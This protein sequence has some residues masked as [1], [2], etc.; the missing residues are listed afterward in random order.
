[1]I[2]YRGTDA[3]MGKPHDGADTSG[4]RYF[5]PFLSLSL[6]FG[7]CV[8][9]GEAAQS[10]RLISAPHGITSFSLLTNETPHMRSHL[11]APAGAEDAIEIFRNRSH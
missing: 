7:L 5:Y 1:M 8:A 3:R 6:V 9:A 2:L 11:S 4:D 10:V